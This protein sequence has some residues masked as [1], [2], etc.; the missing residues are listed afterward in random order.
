VDNDSSCAGSRRCVCATGDQSQHHCVEKKRPKI[1][2]KNQHP[3]AH[4]THSPQRVGGVAEA[5]ACAEKTLQSHIC[6]CKHCKRTVGGGAGEPMRADVQFWRRA[7]SPLC[8]SGPQGGHKHVS[9]N[10]KRSFMCTIPCRQK[11]RPSQSLTACTARR[12]RRSLVPWWRQARAGEVLA[13]DVGNGRLYDLCRH[14]AFNLASCRYTCD[15]HVE[16][17]LILC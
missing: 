1:P 5:G 6:S 13:D 4:T 17:M 8:G 7:G 14:T 12:R 9:A 2:G 11:W 3:L 16:S 15:S 10:M